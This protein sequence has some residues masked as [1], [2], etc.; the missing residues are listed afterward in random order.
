MIVYQ[1]EH[2][3]LRSNERR[4]LAPYD[5]SVPSIAYHACRQTPFSR[6]SPVA[7][8]A[9]PGSSIIC[10]YRTLVPAAYGVRRQLQRNWTGHRIANAEEAD[11]GWCDT[12]RLSTKYQRFWSKVHRNG[13]FF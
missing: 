12:S 2:S 10:R 5:T 3:H 4:G 7:G 6:T 11:R 9:F 8:R 13:G 1:R